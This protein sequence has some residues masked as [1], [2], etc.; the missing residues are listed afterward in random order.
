[1]VYLILKL[2]VA[3]FPFYVMYLE[4]LNFNYDFD[5]VLNTLEL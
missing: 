2:K 4:N 5:N 1:M 3:L